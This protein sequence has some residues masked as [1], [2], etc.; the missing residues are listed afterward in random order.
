M[1][2]LED[3][4]IQLLL[5]YVPQISQNRGVFK[6]KSLELPFADLSLTPT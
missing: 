4:Y 1:P 5:L 2:Q 3:V 6:G